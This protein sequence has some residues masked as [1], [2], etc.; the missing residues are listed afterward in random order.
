MSFDRWHLPRIR[1]RPVL[2]FV[3]VFAISA[4]ADDTWHN[5]YHSLRRFFTGKSSATPAVHHRVRRSEDHD[6]ADHSMEA[7]ASPAQNSPTP[8]S[9]G[10]PRVVIL[11]ATSPSAEMTPGT[12]NSAKA[13]EAVVKPTPAPELGPVLRSLSGPSPTSAPSQ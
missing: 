10:T 9:S 8:E 11:P 7:A 4:Q 12:E 5:I 6:K 1:L 2:A 3:L 13:P